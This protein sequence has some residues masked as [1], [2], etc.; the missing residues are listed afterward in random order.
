MRLDQV[1]TELRA[2]CE[3]FHHSRE[4]SNIAQG[5]VFGAAV[6]IRFEMPIPLLKCQGSR[7]DSTADFGVWLTGTLGGGR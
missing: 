6:K 5:S 1:S 4:Q 2:S 3:F 7:S